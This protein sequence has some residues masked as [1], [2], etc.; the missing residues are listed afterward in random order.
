MSVTT[1]AP[2]ERKHAVVTDDGVTLAVRE[3]GP[4]AAEVTVVLLHGHCLR[5]DSWMFVRAQLGRRHPD[6][7]IVAY[8]HRGHGA[9]QTAPASTYTLDRLA[10]DLHLVLDAVAPR[11]RV[12]I[13]GH[14]MGGMT[15]LTYARLYPHEIGTR[16][17]GVALVSSSSGGLTDTGLG[18]LLHNPAV[19]WFQSAVRRAPGAMHRA[20]LLGCRVFAPAIRAIEF[21]DRKVSPRVLA[22]A[23]AMR[24]ETPIVT[25]ATFLSAFQTYDEG[26]TLAALDGVPTLVLCGAA[27]LMTPVSHSVAVAA[28]L[29]GAELVMVDGAGHAVILEQPHEVT[30]ALSR[31]LRRI[32]P[33]YDAVA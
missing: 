7:R 19:A 3:T 1:L 11:G 24:N 30:T 9:S 10:R 22:L 18:R 20:K 8:D 26:A 23:A 13:V 17:A 25:M 33:G 15:A 14:S 4:A 12:V 31:L 27:D 28:E 29:T 2:S 32:D 6:V 5:T 16:I 21:G